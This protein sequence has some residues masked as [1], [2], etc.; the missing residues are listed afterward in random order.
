MRRTTG[1]RG[2]PAAPGGRG[3]AQRGAALRRSRKTVRRP[4]SIRFSCRRSERLGRDLD[5]ATATSFE[6]R[7]LTVGR[8]SSGSRESC[9]SVEGL[10]ELVLDTQACTPSNAS[11][12]VLDSG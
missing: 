9:P 5:V 3:D 1:A 2:I 4:R 10:T 8:L 7:S 11:R 6:T 12:I